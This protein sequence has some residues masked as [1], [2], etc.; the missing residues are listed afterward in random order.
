ML[1][2]GTDRG[3]RRWRAVTLVATGAVIGAVMLATPAGAHVGGTV[4]HL[5]NDHIKPKADARYLQNTVRVVQSGGTVAAGSFD[6]Q[7]VDCPAGYQA[8]GGG[9]DINQIA[10]GRVASSHPIR[11]GARALTLANGQHPAANG[12]YGAIN[13]ASDS[14]STA[15]YWVV[16][17]CS[18]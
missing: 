10:G 15:P 18:R 3:M 2:K 1:K 12:W 14:P 17:V 16:V 5:W 11:D 4:G 8:I 13:N 6:S 7:T 9:V